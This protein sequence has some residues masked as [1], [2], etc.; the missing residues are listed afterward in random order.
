MSQ[1]REQLTI[2]CVSIVRGG[3][4][5]SD[6]PFERVLI[7]HCWRRKSD[8]FT[9]RAMTVESRFFFSLFTRRMRGSIELFVAL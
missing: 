6:L 3:E 5:G 8:N 9:L 2:E 4:L 7:S 1:V